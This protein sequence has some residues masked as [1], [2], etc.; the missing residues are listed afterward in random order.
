[1]VT[2]PV[3][4]FIIRLQN[5]SFAGKPDVAVSYSKFLDSIAHALKKA[6]YVESVEKK[7]A[8]LNRELVINLR[9]FDTGPRI[10]GVER[11]SKPSKRIYQRYGDIRVFRSGFGNSFLST[12]KGVLAD[13]EAKRL[14]VG[15]EV[16]FR[17]W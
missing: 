8:L 15:G 10:H 11:V 9:Y 3:S 13:E 5:A 14:K 17:I 1:M 12:P 6:G 16:L 4:D 2:D 7:G